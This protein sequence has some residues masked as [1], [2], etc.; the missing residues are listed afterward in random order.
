MTSVAVIGGGVIGTVAAFRL[1]QRGFA[2]TL[3]DPHPDWRGASRGNAGHIAAD[4]VHPL[5]SRATLKS[6]PNNLFFRGGPVALPLRDIGAWLPFGLRLIAATR[7]YEDGCRALA[8][9]QAQALPAWR[10]LVGDLGTPDLLRDAGH[11]TVWDSVESAVAGKAALAEAGTGSTTWRDADSGELE[12]LSRLSKPPGG[13]IRFSGTGQIT[14]LGRLAETLVSRFEAAGGVRMRGQARID[15]AGLRLDTGEWIEAD[16]M[17]VAAGPA[18]GALLKPLG[19][20]APLIAER[21]YHIEAEGG[22]WPADMPSIFFADRSMFVTRFARRLRATSFVEFG[23]ASNPPDPRKWAR[24]RTHARELGL[25]FTEP[26]AE[27]MGCR[28]TLPDYLPAIGRS[29]RHPKLLYAFGHQ[30]LGLTLAAATGEAVTA[31]ALGETPPVDLA[32]FMLERFD[33]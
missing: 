15:A 4:E 19:H 17:L 21:G 1:Q 7:R 33:R 30:H 5:A 12:L 6:L 23:R 2:V 28:P 20:S 22:D 29:R 27:W 31:L 11:F 32:P 8:S 16:S 26:I 25:P 9:L 14:D 13:T 24:L 10:R 18:S 3:I